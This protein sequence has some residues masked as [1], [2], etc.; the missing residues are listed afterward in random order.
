M[1]IQK[2]RQ[3]NP[4]NFLTKTAIRTGY[5]AGGGGL[6]PCGGPNEPPCEFCHLFVMFDRIIDFVLFTL[7]PPI[8]VLMLVIGG[9][10]FFFA[11]ADPAL[12]SKARAVLSAT[13]IG[14]LIIYGSWLLIN[15]FFIAIGVSAWTGLGTWFELAIPCP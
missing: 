13:V 7:V 9:A 4:L 1:E 10:M 11:G 12:L 6:V 3:V 14:L 2:I 15:A 5:F 8:A